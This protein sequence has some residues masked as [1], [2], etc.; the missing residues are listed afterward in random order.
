MH[1]SESTFVVAISFNF[2]SDLQTMS[3]C[4]LSL[5]ALSGSFHGECAYY[6]WD[7]IFFFELGEYC[8]IDFCFISVH[9]IFIFWSFLYLFII[10]NCTILLH[11][12]FHQLGE[13]IR[14]MKEDFMMVHLQHYCKHCYQPI[15]SGKQWLCTVC[16]N[17]QLCER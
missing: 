14:P 2:V 5:Y 1:K 8:G 6:V 10:S 13:I 16:K 7:L 12:V 3:V 9:T 4:V 11:L 17:F 15:L